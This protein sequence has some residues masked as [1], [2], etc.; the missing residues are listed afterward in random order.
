[1]IPA[2]PL[3]TMVPLGY[4][5]VFSITK[6]HHFKIRMSLGAPEQSPLDAMP[7]EK[8]RSCTDGRGVHAV[9]AGPRR[10]PLRRRQRRDRP[11]HCGRRHQ[12]RGCGGQGCQA[13]LSLCGLVR[14]EVVIDV[15]LLRA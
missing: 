7:P 15:Y 8:S 4:R 11:E 6:N 9:V 2:L 5:G 14:S 3:I 13:C 12:R 1:M 10:Q